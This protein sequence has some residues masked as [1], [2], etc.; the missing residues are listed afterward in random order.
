LERTGLFFQGSIVNGST[1]VHFFG[2]MPVGK[3]TC[4]NCSPSAHDGPLSASWLGEELTL[5]CRISTTFGPGLLIPF[6]SSP[7]ARS[8]SR[9]KSGG[10][11]HV[12]FQTSLEPWVT[13]FELPGYSTTSAVSPTGCGPGKH[14]RQA[15]LEF[16]KNSLAFVSQ[17]TTLLTFG[18]RPTRAILHGV[19]S[20]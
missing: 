7:L 16:E 3:R 18:L 19:Q 6:V 17:I 14:P 11:D 1:Q 4:L 10:Q 2:S 9:L 13:L 15:V 5:L 20:H 12:R 8:M